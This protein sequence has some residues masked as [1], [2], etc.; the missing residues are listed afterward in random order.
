LKCE[1]GDQIRQFMERH[2]DAVAQVPAVEWGIANHEGRQILP[3]EAGMDGFFYA[4]LRKS[5]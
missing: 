2:T 5:A 3:G 4:V 1:N